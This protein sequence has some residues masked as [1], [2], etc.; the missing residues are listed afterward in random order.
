L[1]PDYLGAHL[2]L[3][4]M[5]FK[6]DLFPESAIHYKR[7]VEID[8]R[9]APAYNNLAVVSFYQKNYELARKYLKKAED[10]GFKVH[11]KFK[12]ELLKK[13]YS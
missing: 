13:K 3:G 11:A 12:K 5:Y 6:K 8:P 7:V 1:K 4:N 10:L 2:N 9:F